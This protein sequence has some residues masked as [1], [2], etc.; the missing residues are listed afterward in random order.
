MDPYTLLKSHEFDLFGHHCELHGSCG[1]AK[2]KGFELVG[3][4]LEVKAHVLPG[5]TV[6]WYVEVCFLKSMDV[7][8]SPAWREVL[9]VS[10][11]SILNVPVFKKVFK[12]LRSGIGLHRLLGLGTKKPVVKPQ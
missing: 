5:L 11:F 9:I 3:P 2:G 8:H 7:T 4:T 1:Q 10:G 12:V 6:N